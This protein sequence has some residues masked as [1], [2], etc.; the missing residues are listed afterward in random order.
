MLNEKIGTRAK[1]EF[2]F[3]P[4]PSS[5]TFLKCKRGGKEQKQILFPEMM[6]LHTSQVVNQAGALIFGSVA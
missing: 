4:N 5:L 6:S 1:K 3:V 2:A